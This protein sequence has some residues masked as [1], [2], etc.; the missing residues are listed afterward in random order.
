VSWSGEALYQW[1]KEKL[2]IPAN[3][4]ITSSAIEP[5]M[6]LWEDFDGEIPDGTPF[7]AIG[8]Q[9]LPEDWEVPDLSILNPICE[10]L[11]VP[12]SEPMKYLQE[13]QFN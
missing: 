13:T 12:E 5:R 8:G 9:V 6:N 3:I 7:R 1:D 2:H 4:P 11:P 10:I